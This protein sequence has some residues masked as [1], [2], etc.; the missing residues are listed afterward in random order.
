MIQS[1]DGK[2]LTVENNSDSD[3]TNISLEEFTGNNS[4]KFDLYC[5]SDGSYT[6]LS[7]ASDSKSCVDVYE[8]SLDSG[9]NICQWNYW[10]GDGQKFILKPTL[11]E[12]IIGDVNADGKFSVADVV[13]MQAW[14]LCQCDSVDWKAGDVYEDNE[15]NVFD[16]CLM[17][18]LLIK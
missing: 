3:G 1:Q 13:A 14:L 4:Q 7:A 9:A 12:S 6:L 16:L 8:I 18:Q 15:I 10:G 17:K 11:S 2:A 5:N